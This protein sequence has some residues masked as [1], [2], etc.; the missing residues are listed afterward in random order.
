MLSDFVIRNV[1]KKDCQTLKLFPFLRHHLLKPEVSCLSLCTHCKVS[2]QNVETYSLYSCSRAHLISYFLNF[3]Y[4]VLGTIRSHVVRVTNNGY[5]PV[6]FA[7]DRSALHGTGFGVELDRIRNLPGDP[8]HESVEFMVTFDPKST[9][10]PLGPVDVQVPITVLGGP[11]FGLR[12]K[13]N[14]A[15][16]DMTLSTDSLDFGT[17]ECGQCKVMTIQLHN[18]QQVRCVLRASSRTTRY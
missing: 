9:N 16:P 13:A 7:P 18:H 6:S 3:G 2:I 4:V 8:D 15:M 1:V 5:F 12:I 14:V 10:V 11:T 17:V